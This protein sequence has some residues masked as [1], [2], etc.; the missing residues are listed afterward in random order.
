MID[1]SQPAEQRAG[2]APAPVPV[3]LEG[4]VPAAPSDVSP[5]EPPRASVRVVPVLSPALASLPAAADAGTPSGSLPAP[6]G[7]DPAADTLPLAP[8]APAYTPYPGG[9]YLAATSA[10]RSRP[11]AHSVF[12]RPLT[13][14]QAA[15]CFVGGLL[16][17]V[18]AAG[19]ALAL[20]GGEWATGAIAAGVAGLLMGSVYVVGT[21]LRVTLGLRAMR[22]ILL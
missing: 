18:L 14:G 8:T 1:E 12:A 17:V 3:A 6:L 5:E 9:A 10:D 15:T 19:L 4:D 2:A 21:L 11:H 20:A 22:A 16:V 7:V 13:R